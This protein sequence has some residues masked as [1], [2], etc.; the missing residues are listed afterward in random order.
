MSGATIP[1][2]I[3]NRPRTGPVLGRIEACK[4]RHATAR[5]AISCGVRKLLA[6]GESARVV[7]V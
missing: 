6:E 1:V 4:H 7:W 2:T 5:G 3:T